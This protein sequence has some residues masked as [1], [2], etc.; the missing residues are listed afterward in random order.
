M[1]I[2]NNT[3]RF[4][5]FDI[6]NYI[7]NLNIQI[8]GG[9]LKLDANNN[10]DIQQ[11]RLTNVGEGVNDSDTITKHQM[12]AN[13]QA[14]LQTK[15]NRTDVILVDC[16][17]HMTGDLDLRGNKLIFPSE[18][19][20]DRKLIT[21]LDTDENNDLSAV[22]MI[23]MKKYVDDEAAKNFLNLSGGTMTVDIYMKYKRI[24][25][26][27]SPNGRYQPTTKQYVG[28]EIIKVKQNISS[29]GDFIEKTG[30]TMTGDLILPSYVYPIHGDLK[31][32]IGYEA[33]REI[34]LSKKEGETMEQALDMSNHHIEKVKTPLSNDHAANKLYVDNEAAKRLSRSGGTMLGD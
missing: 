8:Q 17:T 3:G 16:S 25:Q 32:A 9:G 28:N 19:D 23:T 20:M 2:F 5:D 34:F 10:Y 11:R 18:I 15:P 6:G 21:N 33:M 1:G 14:G 22:N 27:P 30:D 4:T 31:K 26:L 24:I 29:G 13:I 7:R 12:E